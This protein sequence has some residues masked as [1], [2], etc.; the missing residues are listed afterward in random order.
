MGRKWV[1]VVLVVL[2][3]GCS[4]LPGLRVLT[5]QDSAEVASERVAETVN[6]VMADKTGDIE[7]SVLEAADRIEAAARNVDIIE[8]R[9]SLVD[10]TFYVFMLLR[11]AGDP[12]SGQLQDTIDYYNSIRRGIE[13]TWA[14]VVT[15][16]ERF[17]VINIQLI[18]PRDVVTLDN[19]I[20]KFGL[21]WAVARIAR[22]DMIDYLAHPHDLN[23]FIG[24]VTSG[25]MSFE[26][27]PPDQQLYLGQPNH[28][29]FMIDVNPN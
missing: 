6:L 4:S 14:G 7:T 11:T 12:T 2:V 19:G 10:D 18:T 29:L 23:T 15:E 22:E 8:M 1:L 3:A 27:P 5:G 25:K 26:P 16:S 21:I 20:S 9:P 17:D 28:P 24:L 13:L